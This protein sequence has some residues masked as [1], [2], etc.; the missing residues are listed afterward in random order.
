[1]TDWPWHEW[2][3]SP[4]LGGGVLLTCGGLLLTSRRHVLRTPRRPGAA[5]A[6][7][8]KDVQAQRSAAKLPPLRARIDP[9]AF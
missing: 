5:L 6:A 2:L 3:A 4:T 8:V 7:A 9:H 1:M